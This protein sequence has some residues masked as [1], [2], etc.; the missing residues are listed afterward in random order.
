VISLTVAL[1]GPLVV[2]MHGRPV[3]LSAHRLRT[4]LVVLATEAGS[5]VSVDRIA[6]ALWDDDPP[7]YLRR[8]LQTYVA[9]LCGVLGAGSISTEPAGYR[10][11]I[12]REQV[13]ALR[14][15]GLLDAAA[16]ALDRP[17][18]SAMN[19]P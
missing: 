9:R 19:P 5:P 8:S 2:A 1:L 4:L 15:V 16:Q 14:F 13:D 3:D 11:L 18:E 10:L 12:E 7:R 17:A 6:V